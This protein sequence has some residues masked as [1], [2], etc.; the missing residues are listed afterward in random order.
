MFVR[1]F[2]CS[3]QLWLQ[4]GHNRPNLIDFYESC[5]PVLVEKSTKIGRFLVNF[6][7]TISKNGIHMYSIQQSTQQIF[8]NTCFQTASRRIGFFFQKS[9]QNL[10][11]LTFHRAHTFRGGKTG[12]IFEP[13]ALALLKHVYMCC[14]DHCMLWKIPI[15]SIFI[16]AN[17]SQ[18]AYSYIC[19]IQ[20]KAILRRF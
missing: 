10:Q 12:Q 19:P 13:M 17:C 6:P 20:K 7:Y 15:R 5:L 2:Y 11:I 3:D 8:L 14:N 1:L 4:F 16:F 9:Y 18:N